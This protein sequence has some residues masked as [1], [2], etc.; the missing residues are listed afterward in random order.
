MASNI[1]A[2]GES[3]RSAF[4]G[5]FAGGAPGSGASIYIIYDLLK[6]LIRKAWKWN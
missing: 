5:G 6:A 1:W 2:T 4:G 3:E